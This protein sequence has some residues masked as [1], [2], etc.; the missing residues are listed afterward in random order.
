MKWLPA[1]DTHARNTNYIKIKINWTVY[2]LSYNCNLNKKI[3]L[4]Q[5]LNKLLTYY[6]KDQHYYFRNFMT[7]WP[8]QPQTSY[9]AI[10]R[11]TVY[12]RNGWWWWIRQGIRISINILVL[13]TWQGHCKSSLCSPD[14][15]K[16]ITK[17]LPSLRP[18][19]LTWAV[20]LLVGCYCHH[21][22]LLLCLRLTLLL[23]S[24]GG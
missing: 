10:F 8:N 7:G 24:Y 6:C 1:T 21:L 22:I 13:S 9:H 23:L 5:T 4:L 18:S 3:C 19:Q 17:W 20:S 12:S 16:L 2:W 11:N 15:C 14:E